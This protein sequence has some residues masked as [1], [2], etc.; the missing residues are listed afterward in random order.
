[1]EGGEDSKELAAAESIAPVNVGGLYARGSLVYC[2]FRPIEK[3]KLAEKKLE[4]SNKESWDYLAKCRLAVQ[5]VEQFNSQ[6]QGTEVCS[7]SRNKKLLE[8][9]QPLEQNMSQAFERAALVGQYLGNVKTE[10]L[11][12]EYE[13]T[14]GKCEN[15]KISADFCKV[16]D[17]TVLENLLRRFQYEKPQR[18][19]FLIKYKQYRNETQS[20]SETRREHD[21]KALIAI[22]SE[23]Q[24]AE[25]EDLEN[26]EIIKEELRLRHEEE[27]RIQKEEAEIDAA[28][29]AEIDKSNRLSIQEP[30]SSGA[31]K[32]FVLTSICA[33]IYFFGCHLSS[34]NSLATR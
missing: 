14:L 27:L 30:S 10:L 20:S 3:L 7:P 18:E 16:L 31:L 1:M 12:R 5:L 25:K 9:N 21:K 2:L 32:F 19:A 29:K 28:K 22:L 8:Q 15:K 33:A 24:E 34:L 26:I 6:N 4:K 13:L 17:T 23:Q 11:L